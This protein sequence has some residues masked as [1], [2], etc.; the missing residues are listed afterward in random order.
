MTEPPAEDITVRAH[1]LAGGEVA[2]GAIFIG[3]LGAFRFQ[4]S[5]DEIMGWI[6]SFADEDI[7]PGLH[8]HLFAAALSAIGV[9]DGLY[10]QPPPRILDVHLD[11]LQDET[12]EPS[13]DVRDILAEAGIAQGFVTIPGKGRFTFQADRMGEGQWSIVFGLDF[14]LPPDVSLR[15]ERLVLSQIEAALDDEDRG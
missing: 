6:I 4:A 11:D 1:L 7:P 12:L 10:R 9:A 15:L 8:D 2:R 14:S 3:R 5:R 13:V